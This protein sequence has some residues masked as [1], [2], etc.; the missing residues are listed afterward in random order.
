MSALIFFEDYIA[1]SFIKA[2]CFY[3]YCWKNDSSP[4]HLY[5]YGVSIER[6]R[7][8]PSPS[9]LEGFESKLCLP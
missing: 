4:V 2:S 1:I 5:M 3:L 6:L 8:L 7:R 9:D